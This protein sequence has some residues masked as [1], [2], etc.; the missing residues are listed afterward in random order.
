[1]AALVGLYTV[2]VRPVHAIK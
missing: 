2:G 1:M